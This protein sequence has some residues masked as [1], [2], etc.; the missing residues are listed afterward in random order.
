M[1]VLVVWERDGRGMGEG[2]LQEDYYFADDAPARVPDE[3]SVFV[4]VF[5]EARPGDRNDKV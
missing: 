3:S 1:Y 5:V 2:C 4:E